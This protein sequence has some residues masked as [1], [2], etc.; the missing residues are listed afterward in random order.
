M[1]GGGRV[2]PEIFGLEFFWRLIGK[3]EARK[4]GKKWKMSKKMMKNGEGKEENE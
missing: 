1:E 2:P 4:K 3:I